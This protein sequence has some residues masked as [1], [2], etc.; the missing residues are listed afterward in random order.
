L[1]ERREAS[2]PPPA[3]VARN[4]HADAPHAVALLR[5]RRQRPR[6]RAAEKSDELAPRKKNAH[7]SLP[8]REPYEAEIAR[9]KLV[10]PL[11]PE[12]APNRAAAR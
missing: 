3:F 6:C 4:E 5:A 9:A 11:P 1:G 2:L 10:S 8:R 7:L 12:P